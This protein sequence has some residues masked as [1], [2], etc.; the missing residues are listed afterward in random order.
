ML[1]EAPL[2]MA[3]AA[4]PLLSADVRAALAA[5]L[6]SPEFV[7]AQSHQRLLKYLVEHWL[8]GDTQRLK[9]AVLA[10]EVFQRPA[11]RYD[12]ARDSIVR[13]EARRLRQRLARHYGASGAA[14]R[15]RFALPAGQY[16]PQ[17][18]SGAA[19][20]AG[21]AAV[22]GDPREL[23]ERGE[24]F[25]RLG[26]EEGL[27][28]AL[29]RFRQ[30]A[31]GAPGLVQAHFGCARALSA[32]V[33]MTFAPAVPTIDEA[34]DAAARVLELDPRHGP[35]LALQAGLKHRF[36][37]DWRSALAL[38]E[39]AFACGQPTAFLHHQYAF[40]LMFRRRFDEA[41]LELQRS[42]ALDPLSTSVRAHEGLL[43]LYRRDYGAAEAHLRALLDLQPQALAIS[44]LGYV[45]LQ[46]GEA[47][48]AFDC[49]RQ[50]EA[51]FPQLSI[52]PI[53][54]AQAQA[55]RG[56]ADAARAT[57]AGLRARRGARYLPPY[58]LALVAARLGEADEAI[59]L[60]QQ[61]RAER[62]S[63]FV[64]LPVDPGLDGLRSDARFAELE[65]LCGLDPIAAPTV[66]A[67]ARPLKRA[68]VTS[69]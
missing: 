8:A 10:V 12:P 57:I 15:L 42:R 69:R 56:Q 66:T 24:F 13:V 1:N 43:A 61:A 62:D 9:E 45:H 39:R 25:L 4:P 44:L 50:A 65:R 22:V 47:A 54:I 27:Q 26:H 36:D 53:G 59:A 2:A 14:A 68:G 28:K 35:T 20:Q 23:A 7:N 46:R 41:A 55:L 21:E 60:L 29:M 51:M 17:I 33:G 48:A 38:Y 11:A 40:S 32:L 37:L 5:V 52:G 3:T 58:Q 34:M 31:A 16:V 63:N 64:C 6:A 19:G 49:Y 67:P 30:A 18:S